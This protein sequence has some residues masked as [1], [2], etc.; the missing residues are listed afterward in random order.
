VTNAMASPPKLWQLCVSVTLRVTAASRTDT[1][2]TDYTTP[3]RAVRLHV[4]VRDDSDVRYWVRELGCT[5]EDLRAAVFA[6]GTPVEKVR[7]HLSRG[8]AQNAT[9]D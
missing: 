8:R 1:M 2:R 4:N 9:G 3:A 7:E 6:V 5:E